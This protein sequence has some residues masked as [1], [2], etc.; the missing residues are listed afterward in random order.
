MVASPS[1]FCRSASRQR[2]KEIVPR[3]RNSSSTL[4]TDCSPGFTHLAHQGDRT[5]KTVLA[6]PAGAF[7]LMLG[8]AGK[9]H[10]ISTFRG[11]ALVVVLAKLG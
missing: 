9:A 1:M 7:G 11:R 8:S 5:M 10:S 3:P 6:L 4:K 2:R